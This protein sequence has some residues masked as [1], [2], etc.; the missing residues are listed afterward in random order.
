MARKAGT[1]LSD[2]KPKRVEKP[3]EVV[4]QKK[5]GPLETRIL[6]DETTKRKDALPKSLPETPSQTIAKKD[7]TIIEKQTA[8]SSIPKTEEKLRIEEPQRQVEVP[9]ESETEVTPVGKQTVPPVNRAEETFAS[10]VEEL[11]RVVPEEKADAAQVKTPTL[12]KTEQLPATQSPQQMKEE[13][14]R[15]SHTEKRQTE[16]EGPTGVTQDDKVAVEKS[17]ET[18]A[19]TETK[20]TIL[21]RETREEEMEARRWNEVPSM[22]TSKESKARAEQA[23]EK[24]VKP[25]IITSE[26]KRVQESP[27]P[28]KAKSRIDIDEKEEKPTKIASFARKK[29]EV[30]TM[31]EARTSGDISESKSNLTGSVLKAFGN[32]NTP[33]VSGVTGSISKAVENAKNPDTSEISGTVSKT[34]GD[35]P[36]KTVGVA[37]IG[38]SLA[39]G[40]F[41]RIFGRSKDKSEEDSKQTPEKTKT[42]EAPAQMKESQVVGA[43]DRQ[44]DQAQ[45]SE[46]ASD[47]GNFVSG[48]LG[49]TFGRS[50]DDSE[51]SL[52]QSPEIC[53]DLFYSNEGIYRRDV[54]R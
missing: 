5:D 19:N 17:V 3:V 29:D 30:N 35:F 8:A 53:R 13:A 24:Q 15:I 9:P 48:L 41:G 32:M 44:S 40:L 6:P 18:Q 23:V 49:K 12:K 38:G 2:Q 52:P 22:A 36:F 27:A 26:E 21:P 11:P 25:P 37:A 1:Q 14:P 42:T 20:A 28:V 51:E 47:G 4:I 33:D 34:L 46:S 43:V 50:K 45:K 39:T 31:S 54:R 10:K 7:E 16:V